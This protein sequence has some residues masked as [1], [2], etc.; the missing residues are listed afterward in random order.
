MD[1]QSQL[2]RQRAES[3]AARIAHTQWEAELRQKVKSL[4]DDNRTLRHENEELKAS[5][6]SYKVHSFSIRWS[7]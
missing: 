5:L 1:R 4:K 2:E 6:A 3:S 7:V